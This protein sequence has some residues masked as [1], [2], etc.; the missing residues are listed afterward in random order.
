[1]AK[2]GDVYQPRRQVLRNIPDLKGWARVFISGFSKL[3]VEE[4]FKSESEDG[5]L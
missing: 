4:I 3:S 1:M 2:A 5:S